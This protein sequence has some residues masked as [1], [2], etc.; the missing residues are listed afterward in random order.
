[1]SCFSWSFGI[2]LHEMFTFGRNPFEG[3]DHK[4]LLAYMINQQTNYLRKPEVCPDEMY[5]E[6]TQREICI[7]QTKW[8]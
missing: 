2:L 6:N 8:E 1:M 5:G 4:D 3:V 7:I